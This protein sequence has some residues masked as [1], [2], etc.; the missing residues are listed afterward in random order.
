MFINIW[1]ILWQK[2]IK[3]Y[4]AHFLDRETEPQKL[5]DVKWLTH[6]SDVRKYVPTPNLTLFPPQLRRSIELRSLFYALYYNSKKASNMIW[7]S[8]S[9]HPLLLVGRIKYLPTPK[10]YS[11][12]GVSKDMAS[13]G[14]CHLSPGEWRGADKVSLSWGPPP[15]SLYVTWEQVC[16]GKGSHPVSCESF[17]R[18]LVIHRSMG[19]NITPRL[20]AAGWPPALQGAL[21]HSQGEKWLGFC[22]LFGRRWE[23]SVDPRGSLDGGSCSTRSTPTRGSRGPSSPQGRG[24]QVLNVALPGQTAQSVLQHPHLGPSL[25]PPF[26]SVLSLT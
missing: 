18:L 6:S 3:H 25:L 17:P 26:L 16:P 21:L 19:V 1:V 11:R 14:C 5:K 2:K 23:H 24:S 12:W 8:F 13:K 9:M 15:P 10:W 4:Y 22:L 20:P 7:T